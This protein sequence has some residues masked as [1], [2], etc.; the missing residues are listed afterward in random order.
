MAIIQISTAIV[1]S[2]SL[3]VQ[4]NVQWLNSEYRIPVTMSLI[5]QMRSDF[6]FIVLNFDFNG[7]KIR[8]TNMFVVSISDVKVTLQT[9][10]NL[11]K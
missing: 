9:I 1:T 5:L 7:P 2:R 11:K 6:F 10:G 8:N 3:K 4:I